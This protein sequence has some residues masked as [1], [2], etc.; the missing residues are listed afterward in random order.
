MV[1]S[2]DSQLLLIL[3]LVWICRRQ[4]I[5][6]YAVGRP[7]H[8][9]DDVRLE[10]FHRE[11]RCHY[12]FSVHQRQYTKRNI[13]YAALMSSSSE[14][15]LVRRFEA[16]LR[17]KHELKSVG[18]EIVVWTEAAFRKRDSELQQ[19]LELCET[20][21]WLETGL[22][23]VRRYRV[24]RSVELEESLLKL[25]D[26]L[27]KLAEKIAGLLIAKI[28][29]G[30]RNTS[31]ESFS[32]LVEH[33]FEKNSFKTDF[34]AKCSELSEDTL[35][36]R[37]FLETALHQQFK[38]KK[39]ADFQL[40]FIEQLPHS[41]YVT[42]C[43]ED[44]HIT[45]V[46][47]KRG[48]NFQNTSTIADAQSFLSALVFYTNVPT[49]PTF[50]KVI[51]QRCG[52]SEGVCSELRRFLRRGNMLN[53]K[54][55]NA[56]FELDEFGKNKPSWRSDNLQFTLESLMALEAALSQ[57]CASKSTR[58]MI[59][60]AGASVRLTLERIARVA[61]EML[62]ESDFIFVRDSKCNQLDRLLSILECLESVT[63]KMPVVIVPY[64]QNEN[65]LS[66]LKSASNL[67][68]AVLV[69]DHSHVIEDSAFDNHKDD[70]SF[71]DVSSD[72]KDSLFSKSIF[73]QGKEY[74]VT[75]LLSDKSLR[76][77][78]ME[79]VINWNT[80]EQII[81]GSK[82]LS[83]VQLDC[84]IERDLFSE[85]G[86]VWKNDEDCIT[87]V[88]G[89]PGI[90]KSAFLEKMSQDIKHKQCVSIFL[91]CRTKSF[92]FSQKCDIFEVLIK[93]LNVGKANHFQKFLLQMLVQEKRIHLFL[94]DFDEIGESESSLEW[95][96]NLGFHSVVITVRPNF[97][98]FL[99][100]NLNNFKLCY[101]K[102]FNKTDQLIFLQ[103]SWKN[104]DENQLKDLIQNFQTLFEANFLKIPQN[105]KIAAALHEEANFTFKTENVAKTVET[106]I[107]K[108]FSLCSD[109][110]FNLDSRAHELALN[111]LRSGFEQDHAELAFA[112]ECD[113]LEVDQEM[114]KKIY[115][116]G[117]LRVADGK[118]TFVDSSFREW[119]VVKFLLTHHVEQK[120][121]NRLMENGLNEFDSSRFVAFLD[122]QI[123][124]IDSGQELL[125]QVEVLECSKGLVLHPNHKLSEIKVKQFY[126]FFKFWC[127]EEQLKD[128]IYSSIINQKFNL[129]EAI[130]DSLPINSYNNI[131]F[132]FCT[133][134]TNSNFLDLSS[135][136]ED[137]IVKLLKIL[138]CKHPKDQIKQIFTNF[139]TDEPDFVTAALKRGFKRVIE[140]LFSI[141]QGITCQEDVDLLQDYIEQRWREYLN[142]AIA[143]NRIEILE[144]VLSCIAKKY[145]QRVIKAFLINQLCL[146]AFAEV[147]KSVDESALEIVEL[148]VQFAED[149][150]SD[151]DLSSMVNRI[152]H[153]SS[154]RELVDKITCEKL[155]CCFEKLF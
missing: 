52:I 107:D 38:Q 104:K 25:V 7:R 127:S 124:S 101:L 74:S 6:R 23:G 29:I 130:Y 99:K 1:L 116:F 113:D 16:Y 3:Y 77:I 36:F 152:F 2:P 71:E 61:E 85:F 94:D 65:V 18:R 133:C 28:P 4:R 83:N 27:Y 98:A 72:T 109:R 132:K 134:D 19:M 151:F 59:L 145:H 95:I 40:S 137:K 49:A 67:C 82:S 117:L 22:L 33:V 64:T 119:F 58:L 44:H 14:I 114:V 88:S 92:L 143:D 91:N 122:H 26:P 89:E 20:P 103:L 51:H 11:N 125:G 149:N 37:N 31:N 30:P 150:L 100:A 126:N 13:S 15:S 147:C 41:S 90:G 63:D 60:E 115:H 140:Q 47:R 146:H 42:V 75:S 5:P 24:K 105:L 118:V 56:I 66:R 45:S 155:R 62:P 54:Q 87:V 46:S 86:E 9:L 141:N 129:F 50:E 76:T 68:R 84:F 136:T 12:L 69:V 102:P 131:R 81:M 123:A 70:Y 21:D 8:R 144:L 139:T 154:L 135:I 32:W 57:F 121:F 111:A 34:L 43:L 112:L 120:Y 48:W 73:L 108:R 138:S 79:A 10:V 128:C 17:V 106:F 35:R 142:L 153:G 80:C 110:C 97:E 96:Q 93:L 39:I 55:M 53:E 148:V 78:P